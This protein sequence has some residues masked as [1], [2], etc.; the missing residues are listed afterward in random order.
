MGRRQNPSM[1]TAVGATFT[2]EVAL[3]LDAVPEAET[4]FIEPASDTLSAVLSLANHRL[5]EAEH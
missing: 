3:A 5:S 4:S 2:R 1:T